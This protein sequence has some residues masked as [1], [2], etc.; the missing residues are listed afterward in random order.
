MP[1]A[2]G[3]RQA[4]VHL[5]WPQ[6]ILNG[7]ET[8]SKSLT[9]CWS[10]ALSFHFTVEVDPGGFELFSW[11]N[12][13][14]PF[15]TDTVGGGEHPLLVKK[16]W[17]TAEHVVAFWRPKYHEDKPGIG[18][19][20]VLSSWRPSA[21]MATYQLFSRPLS[22]SIWFGCTPADLDCSCRVHRDS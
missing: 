9:H 17:P 14:S 3:S 21:V 8:A 15:V 22:A 20:Q 1:L 18:F 10:E 16:S 6:V 4:N 2:D 19:L 7:N 12:H 13:W 5:N 11:M